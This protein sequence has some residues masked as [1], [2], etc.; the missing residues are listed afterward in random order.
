MS[1]VGDNAAAGSTPAD[2]GQPNGSRRR[3]RTAQQEPAAQPDGAGLQEGARPPGS[4][5]PPDGVTAPAATAAAPTGPAASAPAAIASATA[6]PPAT[7]PPDADL[8]GDERAELARLRAEVADLRTRPPASRRR[9]K[10]GW[11][12][13][14]AT[15][16]IVIGCILAPISVLAVWTANQVSDTSR[17]VQNVTPLIHDPAV[18]AA[19]TD[20]ISNEINA[21]IHVQALT[22]QAADLLS[23]KGLTRVGTLLHTFSGSLAGAVGGFIHTQV[24]KI[25]ASPQIA[26]LWVQVNQRVHAQLVKALSGQG[27]TSI[28]ISNGQVTLNLGPFIDVVK[29]DLA[30]KGFSLVKSIPAINPTIGL[31]SAKYL[32]KAQSGYR[33]LNDLK[34]VLPILT[35]LLLGAGIYI[36]RSHR[37]ALIGAGLGFAASMVV[38]GIALAIGRGIYLNSVPSNVLPANAAAV[39]FDTLVRFIKEG[40]RTLLVVGLIVAIA[41]FFTGPSV[42]AVRTR[43]ALASGLGWLRGTGE[44]AGLRTGP[45]GRWTY[46]YRTALRIGSVA[47]V[48]LLFVFWGRPTATVAIV[49][50]VV[51]LVLLGLIEL[52]ARPPAPA[53]AQPQAAGHAGG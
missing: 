27:S 9:R 47:L 38:L 32:V 20:K 36:A 13:P 10:G 2:S 31:F 22:N 44:R 28:T 15:A 17:Y 35:L 6:V 42:T 5:G 34:I 23:S 14:V 16:L 25:V 8:T 51:L 24:A 52:L 43:H 48:A 26:S 49:L 4:A 29:N 30:A 45:V 37:R 11:R 3:D 18:Q 33:L 53:A 50:A 19:L 39:L 1:D 12:A 41:A 21:Q 46:Q 7:P 40:L